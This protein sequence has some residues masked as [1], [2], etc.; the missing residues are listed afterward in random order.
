[1]HGEVSTLPWDFTLKK[2]QRMGECRIHG[3]TYRSPF[4]L[5]RTMIVED[6][7]P[8]SVLSKK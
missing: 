6:G 8:L 1:M 4:L 3:S 7:E 5:R 2:A